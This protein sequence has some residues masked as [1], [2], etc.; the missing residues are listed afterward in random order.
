[1]VNVWIGI[2]FN[3]VAVL[4]GLQ[5]IPKELYEAAEMDGASPGSASST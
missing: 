2:P 3:M 5:S 1:M 4:G